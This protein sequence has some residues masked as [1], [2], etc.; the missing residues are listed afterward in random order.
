M[1][2]LGPIWP[3]LGDCFYYS[4]SVN[5]AAVFPFH[6]ESSEQNPSNRDLLVSADFQ[7]CGFVN[8]EQRLTLCVLG[9]F[10]FVQGQTNRFTA[11]SE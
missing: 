5:L 2:K 7:S 6:L 11:V 8:R 9:P 1:N 4:Q 10:D 3:Q